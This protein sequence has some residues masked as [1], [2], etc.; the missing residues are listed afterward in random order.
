M[1][2]ITKKCIIITLIFLVII[3]IKAQNTFKF[4][5][6]SGSSDFLVASN[7]EDSITGNKLAG[8]TSVF[9]AAGDF[10]DLNGTNANL[11]PTSNAT[12]SIASAIK[13]VNRSSTSCTLSNTN[14]LTIPTTSSIPNIFTKNLTVNFSSSGI[15]YYSANASNGSQTIIPTDYN[16]LEL[17]T[18]E[19]YCSYMS[20]KTELRM[21]SS[22]SSSGGATKLR[23]QGDFTLKNGSTINYYSGASFSTN[24]NAVRY[25]GIIEFMNGYNIIVTDERT[26]TRNFPHQ[27]VVYES[28]LNLAGTYYSLSLNR[29]TV[30]AGN[31]EITDGGKLSIAFLSSNDDPDYPEAY[32]LDMKSYKLTL[33]NP[34][35]LNIGYDESVGEYSRIDLTDGTLELVN[36]AK[37][38]NSPIFGDLTVNSGANLKI[39]NLLIN[40]TSTTADIQ[41]NGSLEVSNNLT[42]SGA[43]AIQLNS[44]DVLKVGGILTANGNNADFISKNSSATTPYVDLTSTSS[45]LLINSSN[46]LIVLPTSLYKSN[47]ISNLEINFANN[48]STLK[49]SDNF[50]ITYITNLTST[51]SNCYFDLNGYTLTL[52]GTLTSASSGVNF[53]GNSTSSIVCSATGT[54]YFNQSGTDNYLKNL[55]VTNSKTLTLGNTLN[56][57]SGTNYG[58]VIVDTLATCSTGNNLVLKS[59]ASGTARIGQSSGSIIGDYTVEKYIPADRDYRFISS[60]VVDGTALQLRDNKGS[61]SGRG[62]QITGNNPTS[63][64]DFDASTLNNPSAYYYAQ[65]SAGDITTVS[66]IAGATDDPGWRPFWNGNSFK[67]INGKGYR[68]FVRGDRSINLTQ[69]GQAAKTTTIWTKGTYPGYSVTIPVYNSGRSKTNN[70]INFIGNPYPSSIDW[71]LIQKTNID[72]G[73]MVYNNSNQSFVGWNGVTGSAGQYISAYQGILVK[74]TNTAGG[75]LTIHERTKTTQTGGSFFQQKLTNHLKI[76]MTYDSS[77]NSDAYLHFRNDAINTYDGNDIQQML[78]NGTNVATLDDA[79]MPYNINSMGTLDSFKSIPLSV[80]GTPAAELKLSFYDV[81]SFSNHK[82]ELID[83][84][85]KK[86]TPIVEAMDYTFSITNDSWS[87]KNGRFFI[88]LTKQENVNNK[89]IQQEKIGILYPNPVKDKINISLEKN[90]NNGKFQIVNALGQEI[91]TGDIKGKT[92]TI[93]AKNFSNGIYYLNIISN[94]TTQNIKFIK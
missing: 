29:A 83:N 38:L 18:G 1:K 77:Y 48:N 6:S 17:N 82:L 39:K 30:A 32:I 85:L 75:S 36:F 52:K 67:L 2:T 74:C 8:F 16:I 3:D 43:A 28:G 64:N 23:M 10:F 51:S 33:N 58:T 73:Y 42:I 65:D 72:S 92:K 25:D 45:K 68:I 94:G 61:T 9:V 37:T 19:K 86:T 90:Y 57:T 53:K 46:T 5:P 87:Y 44:S 22:S 71:N 14:R 76:T 26:T 40:E 55:T 21:V 93:D 15:V 41:I 70:G 35:L 91:M 84:Y 60:P 7:W 81:A 49:I 27:V 12:Y 34:S 89:I 50:E 69:S 11:T 66:K 13:I 80:E 31:I 20:I 78:N 63:I 79:G 47:K 24:A 56:I 62:I 88:N 54:L 59:D 4:K